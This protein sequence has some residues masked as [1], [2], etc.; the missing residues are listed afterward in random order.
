MLKFEFRAETNA[1]AEVVTEVNDESMKINLILVGGTTVPGQVVVM[2]L[3]VPAELDGLAAPGIVPL[4]AADYALDVTAIAQTTA[5]DTTQSAIN[6]NVVREP[7]AVTAPADGDLLDGESDI[8]ITGVAWADLFTDSVDSVSLYVAWDDTSTTLPAN[9]TNIW[10]VVWTTP[11]VD[12]NTSATIRATAMAGLIYE[13]GLPT[14]TEAHT[15]S[16]K[17]TVKP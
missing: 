6:V 13:D 17:V 5:G 15:D 4:Q 16:V 11:K 9:G 10:D 1:I 14:W 3:A 12:I 7:V 8:N 2:Q